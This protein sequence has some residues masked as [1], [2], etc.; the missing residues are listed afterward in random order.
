MRL[1]PS[2]NLCLLTS[3]EQLKLPK[4]PHTEIPLQQTRI[5]LTPSTNLL[6]YKTH[7]PLN[8]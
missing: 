5:K 1:L 6:A 4:T 3:K 2:R 8:N 7:F